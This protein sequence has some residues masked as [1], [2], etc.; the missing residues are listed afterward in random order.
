MRVGGSD[1]LAW[2]GVWMEVASGVSILGAASL[3]TD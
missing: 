2:F 1:G 3:F